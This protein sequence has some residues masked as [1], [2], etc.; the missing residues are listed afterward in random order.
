MTAFNPQ[1]HACPFALKQQLIG[2]AR[3]HS[4]KVLRQLFDPDIAI[5]V[6]DIIAA[7]VIQQQGR[8]M[9]KPG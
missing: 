1:P 7:V 3:L 9:V 8:I 5:A 6:K 2:P 4:A